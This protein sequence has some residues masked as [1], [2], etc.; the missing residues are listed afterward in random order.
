MKL[1]S[2]HIENYGKIQNVDG[3]FNAELTCICERNG[4]G[5]STLV[6]F[7]KAMFYGLASYTSA[8]KTFCDRQHFYPFHGGKFG[9]NLTFEMNGK[10]YKIERFF[11]K[12]SGKEDECT[13]YCNGAPYTGFGEDIGKAVF[14]V[15]EESFEKT[16]FLTANEIDVSATHSINEKL[17]RTVEGGENCFEM[18][19][20]AL[21][22]A[23]KELRAS[24][25]N[26][27]RISRQKADVLDLTGKIQNLEKMSD[28]LSAEYAER[29]RLTQEINVLQSQ[30]LAA[31]KWEAYARMQAQ[32]SKKAEA[33]SLLRE[34]YPQGVPTMQERAEMQRAVQEKERLQSR[35]SAATLSE[36]K[37]KSLSEYR[38]KFQFGIPMD[39][40][41]DEMQEKIRALNELEN[42]KK[43][44]S[45]PNETE[46]QKQCK[47]RFA[48][49]LP[50]EE[51]LSKNREIAENYKKKSMEWSALSTASA[52]S[53]P[54][55]TSRAT[56]QM[57]LSLLLPFLGVILMFVG[58]ILLFVERPLGIS[59]IAIDLSTAV[60]MRVFRKK[61][62]SPTTP[63]NVKMAELQAEMRAL[64]EKLRAFT[65]PYQYYSEAGVLFD[66][67]A[68]EED[69][70]AHRAHLQEEENRG[71]ELTA[72][73]Q[74]AEGLRQAIYHF[75]AQYGIWSEQNGNADLQNALL[76]LTTEAHAYRTLLKDE[77]VSKEEKAAAQAEIS[78]AEQ[79]LS[80]FVKKY[81]LT[82][83]DGT[84]YALNRL[85]L[86]CQTLLALEKELSS[87]HQEM[88]EYK[89]KNGLTAEA[90]ESAESLQDRLSAR[91][92]ERAA[93]DR[94]IEATERE[95][96]KLNE[97][98]AELE[99]AEEKL[100]AYR[101][102]YDLLSDTLTAIQSAEQSLKEK[103]VAP[104]KNR[105]SYYAE[106][107]ESVLNE[108]VS[109]D[110]DIRLVFERGGESRGERHLSAGE[111][112]I[113]ALCLRLALIDNMY[114]GE[115]PFLLMDDPF[116]HLDEEHL[117][118]ATELLQ[119][120]AKDRQIL[121]F[122]CHE[123]RSV[124][125][126]P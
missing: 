116:V 86:D 100:A 81:H 36:D 46:K 15:D 27:D 5:K 6:S 52:L 67:A 119:K 21:E 69:V 1:L 77:A 44:L 4:F 111:R 60:C 23:K 98:R 59:L 93:L 114:E 76:R 8:S 99:R 18:A 28:G 45:T 74:K 37:E 62:S 87:L 78:S 94:Q 34:K 89:S 41:I 38:K 40:T 7:I 70:Q 110:Q 51:T 73:A 17:N 10:I 35:F 106:A 9:G 125:T 30:A 79:T 104:I 65:V 50:T 16:V 95:V 14:A 92:R 32:E 113:C 97:Y 83:F 84:M 19:V 91:Q 43:R 20:S 71:Q 56:S 25:G 126:A 124:P 66:F 80:A 61:K 118:R 112:S 2:Y 49:G 26:N 115:K 90:S 123:A 120:L 85:E 102:R 13:V 48:Q 39:E 121:Y 31:G 68:L 57:A 64:E 22:K 42:E 96:E 101:A 3:T 54:K 29:E 75:Y 108:K 82:Q 122:C 103:Y 117:A 53:Q 107:I 88:L 47:H 11:D 58:F 33:L 55:S 105:F 109:M 63:D 24:R 12:K 72:I